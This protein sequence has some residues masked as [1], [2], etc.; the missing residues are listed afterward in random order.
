MERGLRRSRRAAWGPIASRRR[1]ERTEERCAARSVREGTR[2]RN[3]LLLGYWEAMDWARASRPVVV[4][5]ERAARAA[6]SRELVELLQR[7]VG[8]VVKVIGHADD[9]SGLIGDLARELLELHEVTCDAGVA[10]PIKLVGWMIRFRFADQD[11][12]DVDPV[13]YKGRWERKDWLPMGRLSMRLT[14]PAPL[15]C[16]MCASGSPCWMA[17]SRRSWSFGR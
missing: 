15:P 13:R 17:T 16:V 9:S 12:F 11:F 6:P 3:Q 2:T 7:A 1:A 8:H 4:E 5:L 10:D 14:T